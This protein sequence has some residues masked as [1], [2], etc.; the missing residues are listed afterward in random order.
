MITL[1]IGLCIFLARRFGVGWGL[2]GVGTLT[3]IGS[4]VVHL[5]LL[6]GLTALFQRGIIP[7]PPVQWKLITNAIILGLAAGLCEE[8]ARYLVYRWWLKSARSW[9]EALMFGAG[10]GGIEAVI[11]GVLAALTVVNI[12]ILSRIDLNTLPMTAE[13]IAATQQQL[14][15]FLNAPWYAHL[16]GAV[17]RLFAL[18]VHISL[19]VLVLQTFAR[20]NL[21]W[22]VAAILWHALV[23]GVAVYAV[24]TWGP[25]WTE[26]ILGVMSL[27]IGLGIIAAFRESGL[28]AATASEAD[29]TGA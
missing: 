18:C 27:M 22:L 14:S 16:L 15:E 21:L 2:A 1:P 28:G 5:P 24:S 7:A 8:I 11:F 23:D 19:A 12:F 29:P 10:H 17:E 6:W 4:Q 13:Q 9:K 25:Y 20:R 3:F 26:G